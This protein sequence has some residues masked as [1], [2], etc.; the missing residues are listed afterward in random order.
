MAPA[1]LNTA[2]I[3]LL[4]LLLVSLPGC[5]GNQA[6]HFSELRTHSARLLILTVRM[7]EARSPLIKSKPHA[8]L[9]ALPTLLLHAKSED[10]VIPGLIWQSA[11]PHLLTSPMSYIAAI[12][13]I[14]GK[15]QFE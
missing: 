4:I 5:T 6:R 8:S 14:V 3:V 15:R 1:R 9:E 13:S 2:R 10:R 11:W 12:S 7:R